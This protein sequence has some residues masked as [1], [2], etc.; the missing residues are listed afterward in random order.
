[1]SP[2]A[3]TANPATFTLTLTALERADLL[4]FLEQALREK[5]VEVHR[6][7]SIDYRAYVQRQES[8][9]ENLVSQLRRP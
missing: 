2:A 7:E 3:P 9:L 8:L 1:M 6:T 4:S 5:Q